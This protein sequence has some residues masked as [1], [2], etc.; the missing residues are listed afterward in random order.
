MTT[1]PVARAEIIND[2]MTD[3][4]EAEIHA[5]NIELHKQYTARLL[6][7]QT[8]DG[9]TLVDYVGDASQIFGNYIDNDYD[10]IAAY[11]DETL[12]ISERKILKQYAKTLASVIVGEDL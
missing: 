1:C 10:F 4:Q 2:T 8:I 12:P 9:H 6:A 11:K 7:G 3:A 5:Y